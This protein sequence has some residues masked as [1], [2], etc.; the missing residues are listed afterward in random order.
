M[1]QQIWFG[2]PQKVDTDDIV[3]EL[4]ARLSYE[5]FVDFVKSIDKNLNCI[6]FKRRMSEYFSKEVENYQIP[7]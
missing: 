7:F 5:G 2:I 1:S 4:C 6:E 3:N